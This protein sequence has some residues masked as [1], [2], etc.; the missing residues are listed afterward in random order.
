ML[1][2]LFFLLVVKPFVLLVTGVHVSGRERLPPRGPC[3]VAA[4]HN[5]H[6]DT[7]V[8]LSLF[9]LSSVASVRPVAA[10]DYFMKNRFFAWVSRHLIGIIPIKRKPDRS[11]GHPLEEVKSA[12]EAAQTVIIFPEGSRGE[13]E[14]MVP[15]KKGVAHLAGAFPEVPVVPVHL[16]GA[17]KS[18][19]RGEALFVPFIIDVNIAEPLYYGN[20]TRDAFTARLEARIRELKPTKGDRYE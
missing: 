14:K 17:G 8:L 9:P 16:H 4:N 19:P 3:I 12:L 6:L 7:L 20:G 10:A 1:K 13:P 5:S 11:D 18:L 15:F 2:Q